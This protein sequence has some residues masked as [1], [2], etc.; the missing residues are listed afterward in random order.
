VP[1]TLAI[2]TSTPRGRIAV[3]AGGTVVFAAEFGSERSH[4]SEIFA[5]LGEALSACGDMPDRIVVG[6]GPGSYTGVRIG[7]AAG[8]GIAMSKTAPIAGIPS[9]CTPAAARADEVFTIV[10]DA[11]RGALYV[12]SVDS[13]SLVSEPALLPSEEFEA[14]A[15]LL[16]TYDPDPPIPEA[17]PT[18]PSA[19]KLA[20]LAASLTET[21]F[22]ELAQTPPEPIY[23]RAPFITQPKKPGKA[24]PDSS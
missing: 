24:V 9:I 17:I 11:R 21:E 12:A 8:L 13:R 19:S 6:T 4:N 2:D 10:G 20:L 16:L 18:H 15:G 14:P 7:I 23:L 1:T 22:T 3:A 5:P